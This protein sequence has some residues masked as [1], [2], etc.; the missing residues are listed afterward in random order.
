ME[1][2]ERALLRRMARV[3][4]NQYGGAQGLGQYPG[5]PAS[6]RDMIVDEQDRYRTSLAA[7]LLRISAESGGDLAA[8]AK[9]ALV[10]AAIIFPEP[11]EHGATDA[12][13]D[14]RGG[15]NG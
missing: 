1:V 12:G 15:S 2:N 11:P 5:N 14:R 9:A 13:D 7:D 3:A 8:S 4:G 6:A 10:A